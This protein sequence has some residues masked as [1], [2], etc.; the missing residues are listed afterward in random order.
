[1]SLKVNDHLASWRHSADTATIAR[2]S[3]VIDGHIR[4]VCLCRKLEV[5]HAKERR[6]RKRFQSSPQ[7]HGALIF[8]VPQFPPALSATACHEDVLQCLRCESRCE[9]SDIVALL[10]KNGLHHPSRRLATEI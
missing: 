1:M 3:K 8:I 2:R 7:Q 4:D 5:M 6:I 9:Q 10:P